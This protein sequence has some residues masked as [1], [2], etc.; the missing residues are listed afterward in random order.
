MSS[1]SAD[2]GSD[3]RP[4]GSACRG[5]IDHLIC[6]PILSVYRSE[7]RAST[8]AAPSAGASRQAGV[9]GADVGRPRHGQRAVIC[10]RAACRSGVQLA[11]SRPVVS[12]RCSSRGAGYRCPFCSAPRGNGIELERRDGILRIV[13]GT[14]PEVARAKGLGR[15]L[16]ECDANSRGA[17][18]RRPAGVGRNTGRSAHRRRR[19]YL[20]IWPARR[21]SGDCG[22]TRAAAASSP[23]ACQSAL[24]HGAL[25][26]DERRRARPPHLTPQPPRWRRDCHERTGTAFAADGRQVTGR[27]PEKN[28]ALAPLSADR[29]ADA[30]I[31]SC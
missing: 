10:R 23:P 13:R 8:S 31:T 21:L 22:V 4:I 29:R 17:L 27:L 26:R 18:M 16:Q 28:G 20:G 24:S 19:P 7:N 6:R 11:H 14:L 5:A 30:A 3:H 1:R 15:R 2:I 25:D 12:G 9:I